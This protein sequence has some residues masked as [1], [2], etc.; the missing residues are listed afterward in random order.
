[1]HSL[2]VVLGLVHCLIFDTF[3]TE[4]VETALSTARIFASHG[5]YS[6]TS[7]R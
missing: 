7:K 5:P 4:Q 3:S 6:V 2:E 1:M